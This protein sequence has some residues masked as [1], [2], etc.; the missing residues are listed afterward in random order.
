MKFNYKG[1]VFDKKY[2]EGFSI[3]FYR[4]SLLTL[5]FRNKC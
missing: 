2:N 5:N 4:L 1:M 3:E